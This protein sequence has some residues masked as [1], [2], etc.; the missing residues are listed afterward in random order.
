MALR[1]SDILYTSW[2]QIPIRKMKLIL[3]FLPL[4]RWNVADHW[5]NSYLKNI[6]LKQLFKSKSNYLKTTPEQRVDLYT[7]ELDWIQEITHQFLIPSVTV[8]KVEYFAPKDGLTD[9]GLAKLA[10]ADTRL[11]RYLLSQRAE[12]LNTFLACL[13]SDGSTF[14]ED[15]L[16]I[17][18]VQLAKIEEYQK[19][20]IIRS[21]F[22]SRM[23]LMK[24][25][26]NLFPEAPVIAREEK[27]SPKNEP[28]ALATDTG[29]M[30]DALIYDLAALPGF[31]GVANAKAANAWEAL[32]YLD[33][34]IKKNLKK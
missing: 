9:L 20:S 28:K 3:Q 21:Y 29:P 30:W 24:S 7:H 12:Y 15:N 4:I 6:L 10:E 11:S 1:A 13:Y 26:D 27:K 14:T 18:A 5:G 16:K 33:H 25:C 23:L 31:P 2:E 8:N 32:N 17:N 22:G 19:V 34:E